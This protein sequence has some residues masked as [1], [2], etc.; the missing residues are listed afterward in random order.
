LLHIHRKEWSI[1]AINIDAARKAMDGQLTA[2]MAESYSRSY[3]TMLQAQMLSEMEEIIAF[4]KM[5]SFNSSSLAGTLR[6][7]RVDP[8]SRLRSVWN[9]RLSGCRSDVDVLDSVLAVRSLVLGP[10]DDVESVIKLS[11]LARQ[12]KR[13]KFGERVLLEPLKQLGADLNGPA[14]GLGLPDHV[15]V[16]TNFSSLQD[17]K[18]DEFIENLVAQDGSCI[19]LEYN[20]IHEDLTQDIV[21]QAG[22]TER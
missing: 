18:L 22:G 11:E 4:R 9:K 20:Q 10:N 21:L 15:T 16:A 19:S 14:F 6:H 1:A 8:K 5:E 17:S 13:Q 12:S 3:P 7:Q 2:L